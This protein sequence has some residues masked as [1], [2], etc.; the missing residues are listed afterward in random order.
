MAAFWRVEYVLRCHVSFWQAERR[1]II[2][3]NQEIFPF[4]SQMIVIVSEIVCK[5]KIPGFSFMV[6]FSVAV[7]AEE[8][9]K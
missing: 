4:L 2:Y 7:L 8:E 6:K 5:V 9:A 1:Y 3:L